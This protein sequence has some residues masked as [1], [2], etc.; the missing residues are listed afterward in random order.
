[1]NHSDYLFAISEREQILTLL[2]DLPESQ[3]I[4]RISL[5]SRLKKV[6]SVLA[7]ADLREFPP[8]KAVLTF[9]GPTVIGSHGISA[10]FGTKAVQFFNE[11]ISYVASS[12]INTLPSA[13]KVPDADENS[14]M[15]TASARGSFGFVLE[16][17]CPD[18][19]LGFDEK[20]LVSRAIDKSQE[21]LDAAIESDDDKL[22]DAIDELDSRALDK[23][24]TFVSY[25]N[26]NKTVFSLKHN[27]H[28]TVFNST[29][30]LEIVVQKLSTDNITEEI[31]EA[32]V[33]FIGTLP[34]KR[35]C[36]F[37]LVGETG[38]KSAKIDKSI[39]SPDEINKHLGTPAAC[40]FKKVTV[41]SSKPK[42]ILIEIPNW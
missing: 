9:R 2:S 13:G 17:F 29:T 4:S 40:A 22:T 31:F 15:I 8:T 5:E 30:Q 37:I 23:I 34:N 11:A 14:L 18:S 10:S 32:N 27:E 39:S 1:M 20:T 41:G 3:T 6:D 35:Q 38:V 28:N 26:A 25:L 7:K 16:E 33:I 21:I 36:E 19:L 42:F 12:F 24:R